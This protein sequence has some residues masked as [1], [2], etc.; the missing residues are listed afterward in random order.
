[1][2]NTTTRDYS[3]DCFLCYDLFFFL[4]FSKTLIN[5]TNC[6]II[7]KQVLIILFVVFKTC[8]FFEL[9]FNN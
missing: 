4:E 8:L 1:M 9:I 6:L 2:L 5:R 3:I 7:V